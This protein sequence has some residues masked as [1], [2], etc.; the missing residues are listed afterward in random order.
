M[1]GVGEPAAPEGTTGTVRLPRR[2]R[3]AATSRKAAP[4]SAVAA[5]AGIS[6]ALAFPPYGLWPL[7][8]VA[9]ATLSLVVR[10]RTLRQGAWLGFA[11]G[12][13]FFLLLLD[14]LRSVGWDAVVGLSAIEALFMVVMAACLVLTHKLPAWPLWAACL[15]VGEELLRDRLPFGGFPWGRLAF[16]N[17]GSPF[18]PLAALGGAPLVS[19]G[20]ALCGTL[21]AAAA[22][23]G[24]HVWKRDPSTLSAALP[25]AGA[26]VLAAAVLCAGL[27]VPLP[28]D[29]TDHVR[30]AAV[31]GNV[32]RPGIHFLGRPMQVLDNHVKATLKLAADIKAGKVAKPDLVI[33]P[34]NSSDLDPFTYPQAYDK[35]TEAVR[36]VGVP[37]LVGALVDGPD[38]QHVQNEGIVW[39]PVSGPGAHYTKQHPVPF[40][41]YVPYRKELTKVITQLNEIPRDFYPGRTN[42]ALQVGPARLGDVICF[43]VAYDGIVRDTV[44]AG[45]RA[46]VVQTNNATYGRSGQPDQQ[47]AMYRLR[48]IEHGRAVV[49]AATSGISA[50]V[51]PDG[52]IEQ[53]SKEFTQQVIS[54]DL[55]L[56]D[57]KTVADRVGSAPEW[58]LAMVGLLS[59]AAAFAIGRRDRTR[60]AKGHTHQ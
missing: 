57:E 4:S 40:G 21:L 37:V 19:F 27:F 36:A 8:F 59:C 20:V 45:A 30:I 38:A 15:W 26:L 16:A 22:L 49:A 24:Y 54:A 3:W 10:G 51:A 23:S 56:R 34:E 52:R 35:I 53:R 9:V 43:E 41:E 6:M 33:W 11:F 28:T 32:Q 60:M 17:T 1:P 25:G 39:D 46:I 47:L 14:W 44:N 55:P 29:A 2:Q 7:S 18:T 12:F 5:V 31:Q 48:A 50:V 42:G 58:A 13:P